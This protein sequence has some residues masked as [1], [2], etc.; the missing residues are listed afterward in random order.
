MFLFE[1]PTTGAISFSDLC[2]DNTGAFASRLADVTSA[3]AA[4][5]GVLKEAKRAGDGR[6]FL[7]I[8][9]VGL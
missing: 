3:R 8:V 7:H 6:D 4:V 9:K 2:T 1:L 5:R